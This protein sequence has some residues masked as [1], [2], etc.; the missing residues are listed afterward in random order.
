M[1]IELPSGA[2]PEQPLHLRGVAFDKYEHGRWTRTVEQP[3]HRLKSWGGYYI[4]LDEGERLTGPKVRKLLD[5][6]VEQRVYLDPLDT[7]V[8][9]GASTP[10]AYSLPGNFGNESAYSLVLHGA[11]EPYALE[12]RNNV[13]DFSR[14]DLVERKSGLRYSVW[15]DL[16]PPDARVLATAP[17]ADIDEELAPYIIV[18]QRSAAAHPRS[19]AADHRRQTRPVA[20]SDRAFAITCSATSTR[21]TSSATSA[22]SRS[23]TS[24]S[25]Q[26]AGHCEYFAS[27]IAVMLRTVGV[28]TRS[29]NGFYGGEW[30]SYGHYLAVR[31][32]D[33][34]SW[35]EVWIDGAGWVTFDP[36]PPGAAV[37]TDGRLDRDA[38]ARST[39]SSSPGS[40]TSSSTIS[41]SRSRSRA[42]SD[43]GRSSAASATR[44]P[45]S[46]ASTASK[47]AAARS[48]SSACGW[49]RAPGAVAARRPCA[50]V[51]AP[52]RCTPTP[53]PS[54]RSS[55]AASPAAPARPAASWPCASTPPPI[56]APRPSPNWS[57]STTR[58]ASAPPPSRR[59]ISI[60]WPQLVSRQPP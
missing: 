16:A 49:R 17:D 37:G 29:V 34:H 52:K 5:T 53:G 10:V 25:S 55:A 42:P 60:V 48:R 12:R 26:K 54:R 31:Q 2:A 43:A 58:P 18:A 41:A 8:I 59:P 32:G 21:S 39:T 33:A 45:T 36:T 35:V 1:R 38:P 40:S 46:R 22:S 11:D 9:F 3:T 51:A 28:P 57:S 23:K 13:H 4:Y 20:K 30:N 50:S 56:R 47:P 15:S 6:S 44:S 19:R 27:A 14:D 7:S 24:S